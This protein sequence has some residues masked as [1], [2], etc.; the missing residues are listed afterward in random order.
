ML[1]ARERSI[2][3]ISAS[4]LH[5]RVLTEVGPPDRHPAPAVVLEAG[6]LIAGLCRVAE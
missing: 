1:F 5:M 2:G 6:R 3:L 4:P